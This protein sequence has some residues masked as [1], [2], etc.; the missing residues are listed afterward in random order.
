MKTGT[1]SKFTVPPGHAVDPFVLGLEIVRKTG[2]PKEF[3]VSCPFHDDSHPSATLNVTN[4]LF[5]CFGCHTNSDAGKIAKTLGGY[6]SF[7]PITELKGMESSEIGEIDDWRSAL[8]LAKLA[9][10][11][12]YLAERNVHDALVKRYGI[13]ALDNGIGFPIK[14]MN[15]YTIGMQ[16]RQYHSTTSKYLFYGEQSLLWPIQDF[17][18]LVMNDKIFITEGV[19][20]ALRAIKSGLFGFALMG[21]GRVGPTMSG[22]TSMFRTFGVMDE[23]DAGFLAAAKLTIL[24]IPCLKVIGFEADSED[25]KRWREVTADVYNFTISTQYFVDRYSDPQK[26]V[27]IVT[28]FRRQLYG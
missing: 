7:V 25:T 9:F 16:V 17:N 2:N 28:K 3:Q 18:N 5:Y 1:G 22:F 14:N 8:S 12:E 6:V 4:G 21:A 23:D 13:V 20:G 27:E 10:G 24:G 19:F 15:L 11:N 26:A